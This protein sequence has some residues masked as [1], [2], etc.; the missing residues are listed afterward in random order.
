MTISL[1]RRSRKIEDTKVG[2]QK[3]KVKDGQTIQW[4]KKGQKDKQRSTKHY[5]EH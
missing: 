4:P 3:P 1:S 2:N 5:T